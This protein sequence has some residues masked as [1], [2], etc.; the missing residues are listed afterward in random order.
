LI[1]APTGANGWRQWWRVQRIERV[2]RLI[3]ETQSVVSIEAAKAKGVYKGRPVTLD[4]EKA[5]RLKA[6]GKG[7]TEIAKVLKCSRRA[8]YKILASREASALM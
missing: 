2:E 6:E 1:I 4:R 5:V 3:A 8:V 7:A